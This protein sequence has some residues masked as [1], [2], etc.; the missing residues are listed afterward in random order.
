MPSTSVRALLCTQPSQARKSASPT[1]LTSTWVG[2]KV[3][4][5]DRVT[6]WDQ[7]LIC[8]VPVLDSPNARCRGLDLAL[9]ICLCTISER[10]V[11]RHKT[12]IAH[13]A[14]STEGQGLICHR[15]LR[16]S[17]PVHCVSY[18]MTSALAP[19]ARKSVCT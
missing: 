19:Q 16:S 2:V 10:P 13:I 8:M 14:Y 15:G 4:V 6:Q 17:G 9:A 12:L 3:R 1:A 18:V 11:S 5:R 7:L